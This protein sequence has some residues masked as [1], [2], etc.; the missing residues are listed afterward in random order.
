M[1]V[2]DASASLV[3][4]SVL[5]SPFSPVSRNNE[6]KHRSKAV[7]LLARKQR[8]HRPTGRKGHDADAKSSRGTR[9]HLCR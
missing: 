8:Q 2:P 7:R 9:T 6:Q 3:L 1:Y 5:V 4:V